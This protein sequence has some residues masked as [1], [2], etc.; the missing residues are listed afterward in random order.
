M[1]NTTE[2]LGCR[3]MDMN[4]GSSTSHLARTPCVPLLCALLKR[5][6]TRR[7]LGLSGEG[8]D[9]SLCAVEP[10]PGHIRCRLATMPLGCTLLITIVDN[11]DTCMTDIF[12]N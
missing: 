4:G 10:S 7:A 5:G 2:R 6:G 9:L 11:E 12:S 8:G 1:P 3:T